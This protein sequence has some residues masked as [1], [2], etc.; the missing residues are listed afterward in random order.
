M[1]KAIHFGAGK[2]GRGFIGSVLNEAGYE[3]TFADVNQEII[4]LINKEKG[5]AVHIADQNVYKKEIVGVS[6]VN[7]AS[8]DLLDLIAEADLI[9]TAVSMKVIPLIA[10]AIASGL[11]QRY[12]SC[13]TSPLNIICCENGIRAT[14]TLKGYVMERLDAE[15]IEW[16]KGMIG[17]ADSSVDRIVPMI[18]LESPLD[19]ATE[20][21]Y[22]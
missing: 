6:A 19:V 3:V 21:F 7:S 9:T 10:P 22:E 13:N 2:I 11:N 20:E 5:Y 12:R 15:T 1:A 14:S 8:E 18:S 17:F 16:M 4:D